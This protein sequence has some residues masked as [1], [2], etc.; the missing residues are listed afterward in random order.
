MVIELECHISKQQNYVQ[1][2][3]IKTK[4]SVP[5]HKMCLL[6]GSSWTVLVCHCRTTTIGTK[7]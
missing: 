3:V 2:L 7:N 5:E 4:Y 1:Y 6:H